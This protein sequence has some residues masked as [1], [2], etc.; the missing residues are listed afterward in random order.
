MD[1]I[2][3]KPVF[4]DERGK[5]VEIVKG[6][7]WKQV[8][9]VISRKGCERGRHYHKKTKEFFYIL[10]G[11]VEVKIKEINS[12]KSSQF[13]AKEGDSFIVKPYEAHTIK[14]L[15]DTEWIVLLSE[16]FDEANP[17]IFEE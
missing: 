9:Y 13:N 10:K 8:N 11:D 4:S 12:G 3:I 15:T 5:L 7:E 16:E 14:I 1:I 17:D 2:K 6:D